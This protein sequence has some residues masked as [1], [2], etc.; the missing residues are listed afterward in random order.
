MWD[1]PILSPESST[2]P[3]HM[4][5]QTQ[6]VIH[7]VARGSQASNVNKVASGACRQSRIANRYEPVVRPAL[8]HGYGNE[9]DDEDD[10]EEDDVEEVER[11]IEEDD[12]DEDKDE[13]E[14]DEVEDKDEDDDEDDEE[15]EGDDDDDDEGEEDEDDKDEDEA[16]DKFNKCVCA[17]ASARL[18]FAGRNSKTNGVLTEEVRMR[19]HEAIDALIC[20]QCVV[21]SYSVP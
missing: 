7:Q 3:E 9:T 16:E 5:K 20:V 11:I 1:T 17:C 21:V 19:A 2:I 13:D 4:Q 6:Q 12:K 10:D 14:E 15:E 18:L 8:M